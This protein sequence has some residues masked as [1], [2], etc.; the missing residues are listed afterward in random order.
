[1]FKYINDEARTT[2]S[3][4]FYYDSLISLVNDIQKPA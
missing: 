1:M 2:V 3:F 4:I